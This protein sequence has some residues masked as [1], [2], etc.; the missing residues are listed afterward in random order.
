MIWNSINRKGIIYN[1][2]LRDYANKSGPDVIFGSRSLEIF[3]KF[4][5]FFT[6]KLSFLSILESIWTF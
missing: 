6:L 1:H 2:I 5:M 3:L 4:Y